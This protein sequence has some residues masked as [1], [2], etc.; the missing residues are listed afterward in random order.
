MPA[1]LPD[2]YSMKFRAGSGIV[3]S[4]FLLTPDY[5]Q[6]YQARIQHPESTTAN[7]DRISAVL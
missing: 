5:Q 1:A 6:K 4:M 7:C 2:F 3:S